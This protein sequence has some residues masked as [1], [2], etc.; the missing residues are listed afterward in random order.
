MKTLL[1]ICVL[2]FGW[3]I[4]FGQA[5]SPKSN[6]GLPVVLR[7]VAPPYPRTAK[8]ARTMGSTI[9]EINVAPD[10]SVADVRVVQAHPLFASQVRDALKQWRFKPSVKEDRVTVTV[11]FEFDEECD[12]TGETQVSADLP[13]LVHVRTGAPCIEIETSQVRKRGSH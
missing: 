8:D 12:R 4:A 9:S 10:G 13:T 6:D 5:P 3:I 2:I 7:F 1:T 11:S